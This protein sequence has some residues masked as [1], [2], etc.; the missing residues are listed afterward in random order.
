MKTRYINQRLTVPE[1][2]E[3]AGSEESVDDK[4]RVLHMFNDSNLEWF[5]YTL[6]NWD[7]T[8]F[9]IPNHKPSKHKIGLE[10][11]SFRQAIANLNVCYNNISNKKLVDKK[12]ILVLESVSE[13][14]YQLL[15]S[16]LQNKKQIEGLHKNV[17]KRAYPTFFRDE[18]TSES[19]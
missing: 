12:L 17:F 16:M 2:L 14:E 8:K 19:N 11:M 15:I 4:V 13:V 3:K 18:A 5:V 1:I 10:W 7:W 9:K 6:Y